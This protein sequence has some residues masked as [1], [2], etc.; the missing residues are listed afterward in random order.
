[1]KNIFLVLIFI[2]LIVFSCQRDEDL[3]K[4]TNTAIIDNDYEDITDSVEV[5]KG[6]E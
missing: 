2:S 4:I 6:N 3:V 1:M 5:V